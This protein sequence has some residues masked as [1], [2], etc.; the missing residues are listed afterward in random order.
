MSEFE[1]IQLPAGYD[2]LA[3]DGSEI[4]KLPDIKRGGMCHCT[5]PPQCTSIP[6]KHKTIEEIW[7][8]IS[9][10]GQVWR[11]QGER[12]EVVD[13][14]TGTSLTIPTGTQFQFR[15]TGTEPLCIIIATMPPW[16]GG[17]EAVKVEKGRW[18]MK[19]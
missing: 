2:D 8:F 14:S 16:P 3:P 5:L 17:Q 1:T 13:V 18:D 7:Y 15:N 10:K 9:G 11:K 6:V 19:A 4:R 12:E